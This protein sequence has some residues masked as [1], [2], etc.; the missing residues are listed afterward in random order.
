[1]KKIIKWHKDITERFRKSIGLSHY[2][3]YWTSFLKG[4]FLILLLVALAGCSSNMPKTVSYQ[5]API[6]RQQL[7]L[8]KIDPLDL[9]D[10]DWYI[11]TPDNV[12]EVFE[13]L[14]NEKQELVFF[15]I[16]ED[17]YEI[18]AINNQKL[19]KLLNDQKATIGAYQKYYEDNEENIDQY[20]KNNAG[21]KTIEVPEEDGFLKKIN[22]FD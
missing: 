22:P 6:D 4:V 7:I 1:M 16:S 14:K 13:K 8:P 12:E 21:T 15:A 5:S 17:G 9:N 11:V 19:L 18:L 3:M 2:Q 10:V 20:N